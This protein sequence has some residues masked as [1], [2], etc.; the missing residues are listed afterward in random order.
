MRCCILILFFLPLIAQDA[1]DREKQVKELTLA[2]LQ[3]AEKKRLQEQQ[4]LITREQHLLSLL[5]E[6]E[7][8]KKLITEKEAKILAMLTKTQEAKEIQDAKPELVLPQELIDYYQ[9][10]DPEIAVKDFVKLY[11]SSPDVCVALIRS[12]KKKKSAKLLDTIVKLD[13]QNGT[14]IAAEITA[15]IGEG[16]SP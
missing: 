13:V 3:E 11:Q 8:N 6:M 16:D 1:G 10:R 9:S 7:T 15:S 2:D 5:Q 14:R 4:L 12:M